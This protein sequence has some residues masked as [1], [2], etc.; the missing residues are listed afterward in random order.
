MDKNS[1]SKKSTKRAQGQYFTTGNPFLF[2][3]FRNWLEAIPGISEKTLLEPFAGANNIVSLV[4][5]AGYTQAWSCFDIDPPSRIAAGEP[6]IR[7]DTFKRFPR[8]FDVAI[9][10]PPYL[11]RYS[12]TRHGLPFPDIPYDD[13]YKQAL[14][15]LL[16]NVS[17]VAAIIPESFVNSGLFRDRLSSVITLTSPMFEDTAHPVVLALFSEKRGDED[18]TVYSENRLLGSYA[19]LAAKLPQSPEVAS[20][21]TF[22]DP[23]G[24]VG[25]LGVDRIQGPTIA[26]VP[27]ARIPSREIKISSRLITRI[28]GLPKDVDLTSF[29]AIA[30]QALEEYRIATHDVLLTSFKGVRRDGAYRRRLDFATARKFLDLALARLL[31]A[32]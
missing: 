11:A 24:S 17:Y 19:S 6:V 26:F 21:W 18:F 1:K 9:T 22:N 3:P 7:R 5:Q 28:S 23:L 25:L 20:A 30:N 16:A 32:S 14:S 4:R 15:L 29:L 8:G 13:L 10:N 27:G 2:K 12:A 31:S